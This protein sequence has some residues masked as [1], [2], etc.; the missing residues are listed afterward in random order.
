M[1]SPL[2]EFWPNPLA[3]ANFAA[4]MLNS[5]FDLETD[6]TLTLPETQSTTLDGSSLRQDL[7]ST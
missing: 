1:N 4:L 3:G 6:N 7:E 2:A 5:I